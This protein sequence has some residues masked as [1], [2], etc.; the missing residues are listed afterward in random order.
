MNR[1]TSLLL[2]LF[3][4][5]SLSPFTSMTAI[6][7]TTYKTTPSVTRG[8]WHPKWVTTRKLPDS[9]IH[10]YSKKINLGSNSYTLRY[11]KKTSFKHY[12]FYLNKHKPVKVFYSSRIVGNRKSVKT[13]SIKVNT[14]TSGYDGLFYMG[15]LLK[16]PFKDTNFIK[17]DPIYQLGLP[18]D[19]YEITGKTLPG[20]TLSLSSGEDTQAYK[21]GTFTLK[22][23]PQGLL[24]IGETVTLT[25]KRS[26]AKTIQQILAVTPDPDDDHYDRSN[27]EIDGTTTY[28]TDYS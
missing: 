25:S 12:T 11:A 19:Y 14:S 8:T 10:V 5:S 13:L 17:L 7:S 21:D 15:N 9:K 2:T 4:I 6:A 16:Y 3:T 1:S 27:Y 28:E 23:K 18:F 24:A 26:S 22:I 20:A